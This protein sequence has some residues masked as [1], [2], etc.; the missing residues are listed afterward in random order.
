MENNSPNGLFSP[1]KRLALRRTI[2][3]IVAG[4]A[5]SV[6]VASNAATI[7]DRIK[8]TTNKG[9]SHITASNPSVFE[10]D[11]RTITKSSKWQPGDPIKVVNP[12]RIRNTQNL[13][14]PVNK[15]Q[16]DPLVAKQKQVKASKSAQRNA[17]VQVNMPGLG[18][19]GVNPPDPT[20][21]IGLKY[22]IQSI[23]GRGGAL[24]SVHDKTDGRAVAEGL[25]MAD[26]HTG[27]C[28]STLGDPIVLFDEQ[29]NRWLLTEFSTSGI[30]KLCVLVSRTEDPVTGGWYAY[31]FQAPLFPDYPKYSQ[32]G[33][34]YYASANER[35]NALYAFEREKMLAGDRAGMVRVEIDELAGFGFHSITPVDVD[36]PTP[37]PAGTPGMFIR[38]RD[39]E[40][41]NSGSNNPEK[42]FLEIYTLAP[43]FESP[44]ESVVTG[45]I[46]V[47]VSEFSSDFECSTSDFGCLTQKDTPQRLDPLRETVMYKG[48]YRNMGGYEAIV[49]N[50]ITNV[51]NN[52]AGTRWF[53]LR[54]SADS[55]DWAVHDEGTFTQDDNTS[56]YMGGAAIDIKGNLNLAYMMTG[57]D[58]YP[59]I[60]MAGRLA[61]DP[62]GT[63]TS[64]ET[65]L[66]E[67]TGLI[68]SDRNGDYSQM[69]VDPVDNCTMWFTSEYGDTG[70][71][72]G[73]QI[74]SFTNPSCADESPGFTLSLG[75]GVQEV[76][77]NGD[78]A[79]MTVSA[80]G[81]NGFEGDIMLSYSDL[82]AGITGTFS[83]NTFKV[84]ET[85]TA[86][87]TIAEGTEA[88]RYSV[89]INATSGDTTPRRATGYVGI[90]PSTA[91]V[92]LAFPQNGAEMVPVVPEFS[93][94]TNGLDKS[95]VIEIATDAEFSNIVAVG[96]VGGGNSYRPSMPLASA[97]MY[98]WRVKTTNIC[99]E[100]SSEVY[101]FMTDDETAYATELYNTETSAPFSLADRTTTYFYIE[102]LEGGTDLTIS[103]SGD[104]GDADLYV[105]YGARV[106]DG[107]N[108]ICVS[109]TFTSNE[110]CE[111]E[112]E[113]QPGL[114]FAT[115]FAWG[116]FSNLTINATYDESNV[117]ITPIV[118]SQN[119]VS[120]DEDTSLELNLD[121]VNIS[122]I[123][124]TSM[125][126]MAV[127]EGNNYTVEGSTITPT[128]DYYGQ[129]VVPV[130]VT[131]NTETSEPFHL[132]IHTVGV[133]DAPMA[134]DDSV[135]IAEGNSTSINVLG[136]DTDVDMDD[137]LMVTMIDYAGTGTAEVNETGTAI[138]YSPAA[139]F[140]GSE[141][142][143]YTISDAAGE[144][145]QATVSITVSARPEPVVTGGSSGGGS[146]FPALAGLMLLPLLGLRRRKVK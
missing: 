19:S 98:Y 14:P 38:H 74:S 117:V 81:Y 3:A 49:G 28:T 144:T 115:V 99:G 88:G 76:C 71:A 142:I 20:G 23:N 21:D 134:V 57:A 82:P 56:R 136:N 75:D 39:D 145:S 77:Q 12:R 108:P 119:F 31:E 105:S 45:P 83:S 101:S 93:W 62:A 124:N 102:V 85:V 137:T 34:V 54:R 5:L 118:G 110:I 91:S 80:S 30:N 24:F 112:G 15:P 135:M 9:V 89:T 10:G 13:L 109:E 37:A 70:G 11:L 87:L 139:G 4:S 53:E 84:D 114:Y 120:L 121:M 143:T 123:R 63:L 26:L 8:T 16:K 69:G 51:D 32:M 111:F 122:N 127:M 79:P 95:V 113:I 73:T 33:G 66:R 43:N 126:E 78:L 46:S 107:V 140:V 1:G 7:D 35:G 100:E 67:G 103:T 29:A 125:L 131:R 86:D 25:S 130:T 106:Q 6:A 44:D 50:F 60:A 72:W 138:A 59:G 17:E 146:S 141:T 96:E 90:V 116:A 27:D 42:D 52:V 128:A 65:V 47:E 22:Y 133:N 132:L 94:Q 58:R 40:L 18:F 129:L 97:A 61:G 92:D 48:Q 41:H 68:D 36:G 55:S 104:N 2:Q 64:G